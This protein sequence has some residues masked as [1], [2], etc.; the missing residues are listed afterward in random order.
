M[1]ETKDDFGDGGK[2]HDSFNIYDVF[3]RRPHNLVCLLKKSPGQIFG[4]I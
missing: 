3:F 4:I 1:L 2:N